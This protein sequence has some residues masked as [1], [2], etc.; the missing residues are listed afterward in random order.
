MD[1]DEKEKLN[2]EPER[3][4][5]EQSQPGSRKN[6]LRSR[7]RRAAGTGTGAARRLRAA[8]A[9]VCAGSL[10]AWQGGWVWL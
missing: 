6:G 8:A 3:S 5:E 9:G 2:Q 10:C 1:R 7:L 4:A